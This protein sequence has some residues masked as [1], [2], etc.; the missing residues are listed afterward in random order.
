[1]PLKILV[2]DQAEILRNWI[3]RKTKTKKKIKTPKILKPY[4]SVD[5]SECASSV[6]AEAKL[7]QLPIVLRHESLAFLARSLRPKWR[8]PQRE[9]ER[10]RDKRKIEEESRK[11][12]VVAR[13]NPKTQENA[14]VGG[15][16]CR[17]QRVG[18]K[19]RIS[20]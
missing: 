3:L 20:K 1:L 13:R 14:R 9:R 10:K 2:A 17:S 8:S 4:L 11:I 15:S 6:N 18:Q 7:T 19:G 5:I 12:E 16:R